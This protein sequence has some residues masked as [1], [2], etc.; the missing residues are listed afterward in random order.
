M[1][2][3]PTGTN[4]PTIWA[5]GQDGSNDRF[6]TNGTMPRISDDGRFLLFKSFT[7]HPSYYDPFGGYADFVIRELTTGQETVIQE[8]SF[9]NEQSGYSFS[10]ESNQGSNEII[11]DRNCFM[12]RM[13]RD[14]TDLLQYPWDNTNFCYDDF[15]VARRGDQLIAFSSF[16]AFP[17]DVGGLYTM[18]ITGTS[19]QRIL[20]T[21]CR[22]IH[23]SWSNDNQ[24][25]AFGLLFSN[26]GSNL[27]SISY[28]PYYVSNLLKIKPDGTGRQLLTNY[29]TNPDCSQASANCFTFGQVWTPDN[30]KVIAAARINGVKGLFAFDANGSGSFSQIPIS[31]GNAPDFVGGIVRPR[32][33][34]NVVSI[35]GGVTSGGNYSLVS[36]IGEA[37]AGI[38]ST[39]GS[40]SFESGF[41]ALPRTKTSV[42]DFDGDGKTDIGIFRPLAVSEWWINRS[43]DGQ[44]FALQFGVSTDKIVPADYTGDGRADIAFW[45]PASGEWYVLRSEDFSF[46]AFP[47]GTNGD[48]P[49]PADYDA[50]GRSDP[51]IFRPSSATWFISQS[52]GGGTRIFQFGVNGDRPVVSDYDGDGKA[53]VGILRSAA[54]GAEWW[55]DRSTAGSMALQFGNSSDKA[56]QGDYTGDG[57]ADVAIWRPTTGEWF[58]VRSEDFSFYGF[59]FGTNGDV[60]APGDYDG[61]GK[62]DPTVFRPSSATWFIARTTAGTQI[63]Q[64]GANGDQPVPN[65]FVP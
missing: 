51:A 19:R 5:V 41:W 4:Q 29:P 16:T 58:I 3:P 50:D 46:F 52:G 30:T 8:M 9:N 45:R 65:A 12:F 13:D 28:Y 49:V 15:P 17:A 62:F 10:P 43:S 56:V 57:K 34:Q 60:I 2:A 24:F 55:I 1:N 59:P 53:D 26:C 61:D 64:F 32:V 44:T 42:F 14:G 7:R 20:N 21:T 63:V 54:T 31:P 37:V 23:P 6:I 36:T 38:T 25:I 48:V 33:E 22:D 35:G 39:G 18:A 11:F 40:Y 27:P 47:F